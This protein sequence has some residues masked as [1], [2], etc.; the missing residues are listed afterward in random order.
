MT[1][2]AEFE[3]VCMMSHRHRRLGFVKIDDGTNPRDVKVRCKV[4]GGAAYL[5]PWGKAS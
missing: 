1:A 4:C 2:K 5:Q 3:I